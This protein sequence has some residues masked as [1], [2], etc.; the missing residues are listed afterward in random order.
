MATRALLVCGALSSV[1]YFVSIDVLAPLLFPDYHEYEGQ[2]VSE[3][4]ASGAPTRPML[5]WAGV[6]YNALVLAFALGTW[7][8]GRN[9]R[10]TRLTA[11][12][13]GVYGLA[14]TVGGFLAPM[15]LRSAGLSAATWVHIGATAVQGIAQLAVLATG[16]F[17]HGLRFRVYS[18][19]T[20]G[21]ALASGL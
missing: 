3:L 20:L 8:V 10:V 1:V 9:S 7:E 4:F 12:A 15:D 19:A 5:V 11:V 2:M 21:L 16:A 14:S 6:L 13:I 18:F 17:V